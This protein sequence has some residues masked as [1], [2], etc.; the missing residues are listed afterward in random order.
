MDYLLSFLELGGFGE[1]EVA[2]IEE[3][4][5]LLIALP[6]VFT[7]IGIF[8][9]IIGLNTFRMYVPLITTFSLYELGYIEEMES[10]NMW[11]A[12]KYGLTLYM[13]VFLSSAILYLLIKRFRMHY[14]PKSTLVITG[15]AITLIAAIFFG[16]FFLNLSGFIHIEFLS[17][18]MIAITSNAFISSIARKKIQKTIETALITFLVS[19]TAYIVIATQ[20]MKE[21]MLNQTLLVI[22]LIVI[23]N[24]LLGRFTGFRLIE[25][26]RFRNLLFT[27]SLE[28]NDGKKNT[29]KQKKNT[30]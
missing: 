17:I 18:L 19:F 22:I 5:F 12:F 8:R 14:I 23:G 16:T 11:D 29:K 28:N 2:A 27:D 4:L 7:I 30:R 1:Y 15:V 3:K 6:I 10:S 9:H 21:F 20:F 26:W 13:L 24:I 25:Y